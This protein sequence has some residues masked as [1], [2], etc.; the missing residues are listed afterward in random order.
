MRPPAR[1]IIPS[2][3]TWL[4]TAIVAALSTAGLARDTAA[5]HAGAAAAPFPR[6]TA[7]GI[8]FTV[9]T[10]PD[11]LTP[12]S[13]AAA[14][15]LFT[16]FTAAI[17]AVAGRGR[18]DVLAA[19][20]TRAS[21][22]GLPVVGPAA[23]PGDYYLFDSTGVVLVQPRARRYAKLP[24]CEYG[25]AGADDRTGWP[26]TMFVPAP[27][28]VATLPAGAGSQ[29]RMHDLVVYWHLDVDQEASTYNVIARGRLRA[30]RLPL[31]ELG[32]VR[33]FGPAQALARLPT[34]RAMRAAS[35]VG[36]T[37]VT[38]APAVGGRGGV[39]FFGQQSLTGLRAV[40][41]DLTRLALPAGYTERPWPTS[42][43]PNR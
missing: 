33:W 23:R 28:R 30:A 11:R 26:S 29:A 22:A 27:I 43:T 16:G 38:P 18:V 3:T 21:V 36:I 42:V 13:G 34:L 8:T 4:A 10:A 2:A 19:S 41:V 9:D 40:D 7:A 32:V 37:A 12:N 17:T 20:A 14:A 31:G 6:G 24:F 35:Q 1:R 25:V 15:R 5:Q 39:T